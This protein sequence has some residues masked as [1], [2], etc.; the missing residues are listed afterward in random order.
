MPRGLD[1]NAS[2]R[3]PVHQYSEDSAGVIRIL[4]DINVLEGLLNLARPF[5]NDESPE[6]MSIVTN[7]REHIAAARKASESHRG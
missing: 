5:F 3:K 4:V 6:E 2:F 7:L 1:A